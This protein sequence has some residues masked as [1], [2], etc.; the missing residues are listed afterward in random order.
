MDKKQKR[1]HKS[2]MFSLVSEYKLTNEKLR[3][4]AKLKGVSYGKFNYWLNE[5]EKA[6][7]QIQ[8]KKFIP[9]EVTEKTENSIEL[10]RI[11]FPNQIMIEV[12]NHTNLQYLHELIN[13]K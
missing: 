11:Y 8:E 10:I 3:D 4:F 6:H 12:P 2:A 1:T 9:I 5:Y 7:P 13:I